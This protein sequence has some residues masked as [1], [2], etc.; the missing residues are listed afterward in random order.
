MH[1]RVSFVLFILVQHQV[2]SQVAASAVGLFGAGIA[3]ALSSGNR[4]NSEAAVAAAAASAKGRAKGG[5]KLQVIM[6]AGAGANKWSAMN[7]RSGA[8]QDPGA[9]DKG[10][11]L[12]QLIF[13]AEF[14]ADC[15]FSLDAFFHAAALDTRSPADGIRSIAESESGGAASGAATQD[16]SWPRGCRK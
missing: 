14:L 4:S 3:K 1:K 8:D 7:S 2:L 13:L 9:Q 10:T 15:M 11:P 5:K 6:T 16:A 12:Q